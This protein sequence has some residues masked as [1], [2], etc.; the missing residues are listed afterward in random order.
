[1]LTRRAMLA[2][3]WQSQMKNT[4]TPSGNRADAK[5]GSEMGA[6]PPTGGGGG[7]SALVR[8]EN[9]YPGMRSQ[10]RS[11][12]HDVLNMYVQAEPALTHVPPP[13]GVGDAL[14]PY[15]QRPGCQ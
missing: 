5:N 13:V 3:E 9:H 11:H 2:D 1:V 7:G 8:N 15:P 4:V 12:S 10:T 6:V 14:L